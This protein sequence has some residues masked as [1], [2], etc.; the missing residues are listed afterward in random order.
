MRLSLLHNL[1][2]GTFSGACDV[3]DTTFN[4]T[5]NKSCV[6]VLY[7]FALKG[8]HNAELFIK[9]VNGFLQDFTDETLETSSAV[10]NIGEKGHSFP[11]AR[12]QSLTLSTR[13]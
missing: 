5:V 13:T 12:K 4:L 10:W 8:E 2:R 11:Y 6:C 9:T 7:E 3:A 1:D